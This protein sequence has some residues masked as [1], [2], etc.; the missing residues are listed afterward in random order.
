MKRSKTGALGAL[1]LGVSLAATGCGGDTAAGSND[2]VRIGI[3][4]IVEH[5]SLDAS[6][7]GFKR[8]LLE[9]G[10]TEGENITFDE[11]NA[12][13]DQAT[14]TSIASKFASDGVDLVLAIA[15]PTAQ[16][17]A[18]AITDIPILITAVTEPEEAGLVDSWDAPGGNVSGTSDL[19]PVEDQLGLIKE[20]APDAKTLGIVYSSGEVNS[21][22]Q[23]ELAKE[24]AKKL[25]LELKLA[26]VSNSAE[27]QQAAESLDVDA[28]YVPTDNNVVNALESMIQIAESKQIPLVVGEGDSVE[29]GGLATW[30]IDYEELGY[31]TGLMAVKILKEGADPAT[32]PIETLDDIKL[33]VNKSAAANMGVELPASLLDKADT[34]IE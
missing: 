1:L 3:T 19:N 21:E 31:Q 23:V 9:N 32:M 4:Q 12:Q 27:V 24:T 30:G 18:Q 26:T 2:M 15:T 25:G 17:A 11:Q 13:N 29:G 14:A 10:Y 34:V 22:V 33:F 7:E 8:A 20:L 16:A 5:P 6:R 28:L